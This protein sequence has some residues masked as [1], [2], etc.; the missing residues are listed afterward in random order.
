MNSK[1]KVIGLTGGSGSGKTYILQQLRSA[2]GESQL[3]IFSQD[4]YYKER[5]QQQL[6]EDGV[7]NFDLPEAFEMD[8]F[9]TDLERLVSG[10]AIRRPQYNYNNPEL[11]PRT[12]TI[13][14]APVIIAEGLFL[15]H[16]HRIRALLDL[17]LYVS[18]SD[19]L[20]LKRRIIRDQQSRNYPLEDVLYRYEHHVLPA[21]LEYIQ[22]FK[23]QVNL[24]INNNEQVNKAV[25]M[26]TGY[27]SHILNA[28][29]T[30]NG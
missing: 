3:A 27:I 2:F 16:D 29:R 13:P 7:Q 14:P 11:E 5:K 6:D 10:N 15:M 24:I 28:N 9:V 12:L 26:L 21:Y 4:N 25:D 23:S 8:S 22:P 20:K 19:I 30:A 18:V 1:P 17:S